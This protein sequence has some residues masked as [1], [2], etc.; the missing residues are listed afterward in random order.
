VRIDWTCTPTQA[1]PTWPIG[2]TSALTGGGVNCTAG[3]TGGVMNMGGDDSASDPLAIQD[4]QG[5]AW[6]ATVEAWY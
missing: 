1:L 6:T 5:G 2:F 3:N 4:S